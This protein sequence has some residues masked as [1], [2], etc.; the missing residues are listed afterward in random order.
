M[1]NFDIIADEAE[2]APFEFV[3]GG[4]TWRVPHVADLEIGQQKALDAGELAFAIH[5]LGDR[6]RR[7]EDDGTDVPDSAGLAEVFLGCRPART[8]KILVAWLAHAGVAPGES[9]ASSR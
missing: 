7:V 6:V 5:K 4:R 3:L 2:R 8:G 1:L 9:G